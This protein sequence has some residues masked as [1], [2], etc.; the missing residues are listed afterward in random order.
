MRA[1]TRHPV[2]R[3]FIFALTCIGVHACAD[4]PVESTATAG[5]ESGAGDP[6]PTASGEGSTAPT[7]AGSMTGTA[8]STGS[9]GD[10][11]STGDTSSTGDASATG[12]ASSTAG[13][14]PA[15]T[16]LNLG[17]SQVKQFDFSWG[18]ASGATFYQLLERPTED[19]AY[20][21]IGE[22]ILGEA[23]SA[24]MPL[25]FRAGASYI[26][27]ACNADG[28]TDSEPV[29]VADSLAAAVGYFKASNTDK[30][31][32]FGWRVALSADGDTL[33]VS[34][35]AEAS[36]ATGVDGDQADD[37]A[38]VAGAVYVFVRTN[39]AWSQQAY[40][41]ASN[42]G[43]NDYFGYSLALSASGDTL[44][45]GATGE[46]S[47]AT[48]VSGDQSSNALV[49]AG[50]VY[51]F[52][53]EGGAWSQQA[54]VKAS[55]TG[56]GDLFGGDVALS[57]DG[58]TLAVGAFGEDSAA[59]GIGGDQKNDARI[60][61]GA[62]YVFARANN[63][64]SQQGYLK[65]SNTGAG[66][67]FGISVGLSA[68]GD[69][70]AVGAFGE[71]S[72]ATGVGGDQADDAAANAGA[73]YVFART[74]KAW[75]QQAYIKASNTGMGDYFGIS[76]AMAGDGDRLAV[77]AYGEDS[78]ATGIG[79]DQADNA[80]E[81][82]GA[83]YVFAR[84]NNAWSQEAYVKAVN[85]GA[86]DYFGWS[87]SLSADGGALAV[88]AVYEDSVAVSIDGDP[89]DDSVESAGAAY[90]FVRAAQSWSHRAYVKAG[91]AGAGDYFGH[92][93]AMTA[94]GNILAVAAVLERSAATGIGGDQSDDSAPFAGAVCLY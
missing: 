24:T 34:A 38:E 17:F 6:G 12:D 11:S 80:A 60:N 64:W 5:Q 61:A 30:N 58:D 33:A 77:G 4:P 25:H 1:S 31:D 92:R 16:A 15:A 50:A 85:A 44:V 78:A 49:S 66:D 68:D 27:R 51:V 70:L 2:P 83:A 52:V 8:A 93:V 29:A 26:L 53:R 73:V 35:N 63:A 87:V 3:S 20:A 10:A 91:T 88:G 67:G 19:V 89:L 74:N 55:N 81:W 54:Y 23:I 45:V 46:S 56:E 82:A 41:K 28:C 47:A 72:A 84:T 59:T 9:T 69:T 57:A 71:A 18:T 65:A 22:E 43:A 90:V 40:L 21:Q 94:D 36:A 75:T 48:G 13:S 39:D 42:T 7:S 62:A 76:L 79:G 37:S 86:G 32:G 14:P